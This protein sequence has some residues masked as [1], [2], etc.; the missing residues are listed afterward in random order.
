GVGRPGGR[1][2]GTANRGGTTGNRPPQG[3]SRFQKAEPTQ[4]EIQDQIKQTLARLQGGGKSG[5]GRSK[6]RRDKRNERGK[7]LVEGQDETKVLRVTE[8]ISA[9]DLASLLDVSV[10]EII[11]VC[12]S[13]G[14]FVSINQRLDAEAI[15]IIADE[16][17]YEVEFS[18]SD[19]E[20]GE[21]IHVDSP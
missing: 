13:L 18:K 17:G 20:E 21:I 10:N 16:F 11:S 5:G 9:N 6:N 3:T 2:P 8:F 7:E 1:P 4:K 19:E 14:L 12:M 15:T